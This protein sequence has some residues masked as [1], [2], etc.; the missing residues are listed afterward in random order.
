[1]SSTAFNE[2]D[3]PRGTGGKFTPKTQRDA[4]V[5]LDETL[6]AAALRAQFIADGGRIIE[7]GGG[8]AAGGGEAWYVDVKRV[9][10]LLYEREW[11]VDGKLHRLDGPAIQW[12]GGVAAGGSESWYVD[13]KE[14]RLDGPALVLAGGVA[15]G[16]YESWYVDGRKVEPTS[17]MLAAW[18][19]NPTNPANW[20]KP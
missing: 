13:G 14:H 15:A 4:E 17:A 12:G 20:P 2:S 9:W 8:V 5:S 3:H 1:M 10:H 18:A 11:H 6:D 16:G 7:A 19:A